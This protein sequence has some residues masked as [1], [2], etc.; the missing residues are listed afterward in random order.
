VLVLGETGTGKEVM[1]GQIH[2]SSARV[3]GKFVP[4]NCAAI[5]ETLIESELFGYKKGA[6]TGANTD[7]EGLIRKAHKGTLFLDEIGD[8]HLHMQVKLLRVIQE[9]KF[10]RLGSTTEEE[11]DFRL[12][13]ATHQPLDDRIEKG[14]FRQD[15]YFRINTIILNLPPLR[16]RPED[17]LNLANEFLL[18]AVQESHKSI[19]GFDESASTLLLHQEW[20]G[21]IREL[22]NAIQRAVALATPEGNDYRMN[23]KDFNFLTT[24]VPF[25][26]LPK[27][28][29]AKDDF[30]RN[31]VKKAI[32]IHKGNKTKA[33]KAL[34]VDP[35]T[36][37]RHLLE[38]DKED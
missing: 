19:K 35:K 37:Y 2:R 9:K 10:T 38:D 14:F 1:A 20:P 36:L 7:R 31:Y 27:L 23:A 13:C 17:L 24:K 32:L 16:E 15:L 34:G 11:S 25:D 6:F 8:L 21:N 18:E 3:S 26:T 28:S 29:D 33:A 12:I 30:I 5:P 22:K 4:I